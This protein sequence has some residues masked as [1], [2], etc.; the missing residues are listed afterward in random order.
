MPILAR[1][2]LVEG[3]I[4]DIKLSKLEHFEC[5]ALAS[6]P[7]RVRNP[8]RPETGTKHAKPVKLTM[9]LTYQPQLFLFAG[10]NVYGDVRNGRDVPDG[11]L[12]QSLQESYA[13]AAR[14]PGMA[15]L[16]ST[17]PHLA[18]WDDHDYGKNDAGAEFA[19]RHEAQQLFLQ[20]WDVPLTD[21]RHQREGIYHS[22]TFGPSGQ[23]VQ[24]ILLDTRFFRSPPQAYGPAQCRW[25][26]A[27]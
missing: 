1:L 13:Q 25:S 5:I 8:R 14:V 18:T 7:L 15:R 22:Q 27:L 23:R 11:E 6:N 9:P 26:R 10:D 19:G 20:F 16:R 2:T 3:A 24:V 12:I 4:H 21:V 17:I